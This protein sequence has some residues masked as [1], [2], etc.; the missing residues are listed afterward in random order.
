MTALPKEDAKTRAKVAADIVEDLDAL[1]EL[2]EEMH[3]RKSIPGVRIYVPTSD[4]I[5]CTDLSID[6][7]T[8]L[9]PNYTT[10][11]SMPIMSA[12]RMDVN[13]M[14][15]VEAFDA[16]MPAY[17]NGETVVLRADTVRIEVFITDLQVI[18]RD[19]RKSYISVRAI[20]AAEPIMF[21]PMEFQRA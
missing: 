15:A 16:V 12:P 10:G 3:T 8:L 17:R 21:S 20:A 18:V 14:I 11:R 13:A 2:I 4:G 1:R 9:E 5:P 19:D 7:G 6:M